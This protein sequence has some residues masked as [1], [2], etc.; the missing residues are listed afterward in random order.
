[1]NGVDSAAHLSVEDAIDG[2]P[3]ARLS[4]PYRWGRAR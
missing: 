4:P 2:H 1:M 3:S